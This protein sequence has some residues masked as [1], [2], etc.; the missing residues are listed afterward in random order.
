MDLRINSISFNGRTECAYGLKQAAIEARNIEKLKFLTKCSNPV[1]KDTEI[2]AA[3]A[4]LNAYL[5]MVVHDNSALK[6]FKSFLDDD[7]IINM[8]KAK[9][10]KVN[11]ALGNINPFVPFSE[12]F[13]QQA[14]DNCKLQDIVD[15]F[16]FKI[17]Y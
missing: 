13:R 15:T 5:D 8:L 1:N 17:E 12:A 6:T 16:L 10:A 2:A 7:K 9:L 14:A 11:F 4:S 3:T